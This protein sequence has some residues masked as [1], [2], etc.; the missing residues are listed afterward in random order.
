MLPLLLKEAES[1]NLVSASLAVVVIR[2]LSAE[3]VLTL[4]VIPVIYELFHFRKA[5]RQREKQ[6]REGIDNL[7]AE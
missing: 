5:K 1:G 3:T 2:G 6:N 4:I 7:T